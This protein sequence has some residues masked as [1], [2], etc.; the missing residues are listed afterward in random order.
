M[1]RVLRADGSA[2][3][4]RCGFTETARERMLGLL[5]RESLAAGEGLWFPNHSSVHTF[6]MRFPID[7]AFLDSE[8]RVA[9]LYHSLPPWRH[10]W[11][12]LSALRGGI[13][14]ASAGLFRTHQ[15]E[16]GEPLRVC[17]IS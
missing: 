6:F 1:A 8:G 17:L 13:L 9:A 12:H 11:I 16:K 4:D 10:T 15:I 3:L 7:V 14:E 2:L 5:P